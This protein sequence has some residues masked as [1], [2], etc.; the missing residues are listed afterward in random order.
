MKNNTTNKEVQKSERPDSITVIC[1]LNFIL[2]A[3]FTLTLGIL[4]ANPD[5]IGNTKALNI[6][7][8]IILDIIFIITVYYLWNMRKTG[9]YLYLVV[10]MVSFIVMSIFAKGLGSAIINFVAFIP[11]AIMDAVILNYV[12]L[13]E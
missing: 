1:I 7:F 11:L 10:T 5:W 12:T 13:M 6:F 9:A 4:L 8:F 3:I 2:G